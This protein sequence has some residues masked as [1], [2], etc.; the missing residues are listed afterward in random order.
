MIE[1]NKDE[2]QSLL[3]TNGLLQFISHWHL[4]KKRSPGA[5]IFL[6]GYIEHTDWML[7]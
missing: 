3:M 2:K 6:L 5:L 7:K 4:R 1:V